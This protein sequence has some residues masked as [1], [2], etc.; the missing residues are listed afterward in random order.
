MNTE[1]TIIFLILIITLIMFAW[2]RFRYDIVAMAALMA[3]VLAKL[4]EP[5]NAF[6]GFGHPAV[7]TVACVLI[8]SNVSPPFL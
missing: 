6:S 1:H 5:A 8:I 4:I 2:G 7:I 3:C